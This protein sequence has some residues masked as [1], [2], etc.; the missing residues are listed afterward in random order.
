[1]KRSFIIALHAGYWLLYL[2]LLGIFLLFLE[3]G[4]IKTISQRNE[5]VFGFIKIMSVVT[6]LPGLTGFYTFYLLLFDKYLSKKRI[7]ALCIAGVTAALLAGISGIVG[8][9]IFTSGKIHLNNGYQE[10]LVILIFMSVLGLI[11]GI[12]AL[13]MKGFINWYGDIKVKKELQQK[14]FE[15]ELALVRSQ[16]SPHFLFNSINN[17]DVL[18]AKDAAMASDYLNK[19][20]HIMRFMLYETKT[21]NI[22]LQKEIT[23]IEKYIDLQKIR[24]ANANFVQYA[25]EGDTG[26]WMIAPMLFIPFIENAFKHSANKKTGEGI[27]VKIAVTDKALDFYCENHFI[28]NPLT[29]Q[30]A[31]GLGNDLIKKRLNLLYPSKHSL[32]TGIQNA[33]YKVHLTIQAH[34]D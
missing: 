28:E 15:T 18:I 33:V 30:E 29:Q 17:I 16:L 4:G 7:T 1:M 26:K 6:L 21:E 2:L 32:H 13:V 9:S 34:E 25:T 20:A 3:A 14:N 5:Q 27:I 31:G 23:Y 24:T 12:I 22:P 19:L 11:H 8:I 10:M